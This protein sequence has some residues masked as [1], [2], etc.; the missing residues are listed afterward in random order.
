[1]AEFSIRALTGDAVRARTAELSGI[2]IACVEGGASVS[3]LAPLS[4]HA[5]EAFWHGVADSVATGDRVLLVAEDNRTGVILGTVQVVI[6]QPPNQPHRADVAKML[7]APAARRCGIGG[8][9]LEAAIDA[10]RKAGKTLLVLDT[11]TGSD[12]E[13][14]YERLGW[15]RVGVIPN[16]SLLPDGRPCGTTV[17][18]KDLA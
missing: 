13:R 5:A 1:M 17:F 7:V 2:L 12:A 6:G 4:N 10:A 15:I 16:Y 9:L 18:Y 11:A 3:F 8:Q 14:L